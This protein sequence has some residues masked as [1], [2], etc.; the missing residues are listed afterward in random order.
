MMTGIN[1]VI[2]RE[3]NRV[4]SELLELNP[5]WGDDRLYEEARR[6]VIAQL[7]H[8]TYNEY[9][10]SIIGKLL[11]NFV[12]TRRKRSVYCYRSLE[13]CRILVN[14]EILSIKRQDTQLNWKFY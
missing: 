3:H 13:N 8:I 14:L 11:H 10:P 7:Q 5:H 9:V 2:L 6:I 4:A 1:L 12:Y